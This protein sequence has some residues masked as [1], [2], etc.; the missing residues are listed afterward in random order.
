MIVLRS[1]IQLIKLETSLNMDVW[2][3]HGLLAT[4]AILI[5][6]PIGILRYRYTFTNAWLSHTTLQSFGLA[7][8]LIDTATGLMR[9]RDYMQMH[10]SAGLILTVLLL[11]Q[12][13]LGHT[14][15]NAHVDGVARRYIGW[16]HLVQGCSCLAVGWFSVVTGLV[17]AGHKSAFI[18]L[19]GLSSAAEVTAIP[20][21]LGSTRWRR[22][23]Y[24]AITDDKE[25]N[26]SC[27]A[28]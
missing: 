12:L 16:A 8:T 11:S 13:C 2:L 19:V 18:I 6:F 4:V 24:I 20:V 22:F 3:L 28:C 14:T 10:Q 26:S 15:R 27:S 1:K 23:G 25:A 7:F 17:L 9:G 21:I 5:I